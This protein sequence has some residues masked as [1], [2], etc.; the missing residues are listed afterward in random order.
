M[1]DHK[2]EVELVTPTQ[3][4]MQKIMDSERTL[5]PGG[6]QKGSEIHDPELV[7][8]I[9][10][11][12]LAPLDVRNPVTRK[13]LT[14]ELGIS[15]YTLARIE[16]SKQFRDTLD[17]ITEGTGFDAVVI[18]EIKA[19]MATMALQGNLSAQ[20]LVMEASGGLR[21]KLPAITSEKAELTS[22]SMTDDELLEALN[23]SE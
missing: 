3:R 10:Y 6:K 20:R 11:W 22:G 17:V 2:H 7:E 1:S 5:P 15:M 9:A 14:E 19:T 8:L 18:R 23:L 16:R 12:V 21:G 4:R 13:E